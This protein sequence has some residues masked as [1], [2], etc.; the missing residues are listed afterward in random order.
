VRGEKKEETISGGEK[1]WGGEEKGGEGEKEE[2]SGEKKEEE[3]AHHQHQQQVHAEEAA[4]SA[5]AEGP[6]SA[7]TAGRNLQKLFSAGSRRQAQRWYMG[8]L[9]D[10]QARTRWSSEPFV[11]SGPPGAA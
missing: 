1:G 5:A 8:L 11:R 7:S 10:R 6:N 4:A 9:E 2:V 3:S